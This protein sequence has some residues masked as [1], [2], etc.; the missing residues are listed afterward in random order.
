MSRS[1]QLVSADSRNHMNRIFDFPQLD[2]IRKQ[3]LLELLQLKATE[4]YNK[5][6]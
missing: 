2:N 1:D 3:K 6:I 4:R 5:K